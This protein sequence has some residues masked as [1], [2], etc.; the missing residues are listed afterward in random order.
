LHT[1]NRAYYEANLAR[2]LKLADEAHL[3]HIR[4]AHLR[5]AEF[6]GVAL[7]AMEAIERA[8]ESRVRDDNASGVAA[9]G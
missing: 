6:Y 8:D 1:F 7:G 2:N 3:P 5:L 9:V 4:E